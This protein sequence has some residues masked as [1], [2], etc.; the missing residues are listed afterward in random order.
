MVQW[1]KDLVLLLQRLGSLLWRRFVPRPWNFHMPW[2]RPPP[3]FFF[4]KIHF[5]SDS[6]HVS[7]AQYT[8]PCDLSGCQYW[9][10]F[11]SCDLLCFGRVLTERSGSFCLVLPVR[12][13]FDSQ[14]SFCSI[15]GPAASSTLQAIL[16]VEP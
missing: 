4:F 15:L 1:V 10:A 14:D 13:G 7:S 11:A 12:V 8:A 6:G 3:I 16:G 2:I 5:L 9:T